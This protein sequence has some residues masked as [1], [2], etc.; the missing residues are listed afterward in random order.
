M[1]YFTKYVKTIKEYYKNCKTLEFQE[2]RF[3]T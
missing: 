2:R 3:I 1:K